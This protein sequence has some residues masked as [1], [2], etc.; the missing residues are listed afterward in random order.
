MAWTK[1]LS[2]VRTVQYTTGVLLITGVNDISPM[3]FVTDFFSC[4]F[5]LIETNKE[6]EENLLQVIW[7]FVFQ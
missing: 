2:I 7:Q 5:P 1:M 6:G 4:R 3:A